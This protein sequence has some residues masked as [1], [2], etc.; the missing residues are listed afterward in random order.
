MHQA[1]TIAAELEAVDLPAL[2]AALHAAYPIAIDVALDARGGSTHVDARLVVADAARAA[3]LAARL[4][5]ET[6]DSLSNQLGVPVV[7][8]AATPTITTA[9]V[10]A[11]MPAP[12]SWPSLAPSGTPGT[13][14]G[15]SPLDELF[16]R[17]QARIGWIGLL[18]GT[19]AIMC[20][21]ACGAF[22]C[23]LLAHR[24]LRPG[25]DAATLKHAGAAEVLDGF[26]QP[27]GVRRGASSS[28]LVQVIAHGFAP[29]PPPPAGH[30]SERR[31][32]TSI[33]LPFDR[34]PRPFQQASRGFRR[35]P[36]DTDAEAEHATGGWAEYYADDGQPYWSNGA[37][38]VWEPPPG[39]RVRS[40]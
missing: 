38:S 12:P 23:G 30:L 35:L 20:V 31:G 9:L 24:C 19:G 11:P 39:F 4:E 3:E 29:P 14:V 40:C 10:A 33:P 34:P 5:A 25:S 37:E 7:A 8:K 17:A 6:V 36:G 21:C 2:R 22:C 26:D 1:F 32:S 15:G 16:E 18:A 27:A 13:S 28:S